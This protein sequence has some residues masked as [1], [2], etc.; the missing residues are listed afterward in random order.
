MPPDI[1]TLPPSEAATVKVNLVT[2]G[3]GTTASG[4][5]ASLEQANRIKKYVCF[6]HI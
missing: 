6:F 1:S 2:V 4:I 5:G 3:V